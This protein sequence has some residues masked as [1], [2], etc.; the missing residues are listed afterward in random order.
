MRAIPCRGVIFHS[1]REA[2]E[3]MERHI[4]GQRAREM[5]SVYTCVGPKGTRMPLHWHFGV[6]P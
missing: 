6:L 4:H 3:A 1:Q 2:H 5:V